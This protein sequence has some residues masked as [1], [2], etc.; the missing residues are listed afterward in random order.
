MPV[1]A[2]MGTE[3]SLRFTCPDVVRVRAREHSA[4]GGGGRAALRILSVWAFG[5]REAIR[6][7]VYSSTKVSKFQGLSAEPGPQ[8]M[9]PR[10]GESG[11]V[12]VPRRLP[13]WA[14]HLT[15]MQKREVRIY[16]DHYNWRALITK[17]H[18]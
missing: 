13:R 7:Q 15:S 9:A 5:N 12:P 17:S 14:L 3:A 2:G 1:V 18:P 4:A 16:P 10:E 6:L 11:P 8:E